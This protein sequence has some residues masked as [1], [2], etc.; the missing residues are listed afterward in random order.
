MK[1]LG[2]VAA[3]FVVV[4]VVSA[5]GGRTVW[6]E[7]YTAE[8]AKRGAMAYATKCAYCHGDTAL[9][10]EGPALTGPLFAANWDG[11]PLNDLVERIRQTMPAD[12]PGSMSRAELAD[13]VAHMLNIAKM[14]AGT[15]ALPTDAAALMQIKYVSTRPQ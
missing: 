11:V 3:V 13:V 10:G 15:T 6:D 14:P 9:G 2:S 1:I 8:Q 5:Q 4:S 12:N 7:V